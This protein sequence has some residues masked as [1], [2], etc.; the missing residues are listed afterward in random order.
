MFG[1]LLTATML[2]S[3]GPV[4]QAREPTAFFKK[5]CLDCHSA[6]VRKGG[7]DLTALKLD[8]THADNFAKWVKIH[9]RIESGEMPPKKQERPET[10]EKNSTVN[11]LKTALIKTELEQL[12]N[13]P[14]TGLRRLTRTEYENT[15]RDLFDMPGILLRNDLPADGS[16]H[17]FD[18][19]SDALD[20]SH[21]NLAKYIE[22]ADRVLTMA[23]A[24]QPNPP[25]RKTQRVSIAS[26]WSPLGACILEGD[27][28]MLKNKE[29]D[30]HYPPAGK[31]RHIDYG[32][33]LALGMHTDV[34]PGASVGVFRH[35][36]DSFRPSFVEFTTIYPGMYRIK[37]AFWSF[38]WDKGKVLP[39]KR[40]EVARLDVW[41]ITGDGRGTGHPSSLLGYFDAPSIKE[42]TYEFTRWLNTADSF[43]FNFTTS[44]IGHEIRG[45]KDRLAGW[46]GPGLACDGLEVEGPIHDHWPPASH[47]TLFGDLPLVEFKQDKQPGVKPPKHRELTQRYQARNQPD[48][49]P[50]T[51]KLW[52]VKSDRPLVDADRL[53]ASFLPRAFRKPVPAELRRPYLDMVDKRLK[54][55]DCFE[56]AM[57]WAYQAALCSPDFL[58]HFEEVDSQP[59]EKTPAPRV[60]VDDFALAARLSY[61]FWNSMP[62]EKLTALAASHKLRQNTVLDQE[63]ERLLKDP[64][65]QRFREDFLGQWLKLRK[66]AANDPDPKLYAGW[67]VDLQDAMVAE[68]NAYFQELLDKDLGASYLIKS[69]FAMLNERL[70]KQYGIPGVVGSKIRRVALPTGSA[71][72]PFLTQAAILKITANGTTT[73]P[74]PRGAFVMD[75]LLGSPPE[76]PPANV[77]AVEPDVRGATTIRAQLAKHRDNATCAA[78]HAKIDP[79]GFALES[80]DVIGGQRERYQSITST[81]PPVD[82]SGVLPDGRPF[83][84]IHE[85][86]TLV[87]ADST[88]LLKN[89][90]ERF[91]IYSTG[92]GLLF[93]DRDAI[94]AIVTKTQKQG[95]GIRTL[96]HEL[97][98]SD[99]FQTR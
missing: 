92:R 82:P 78:C 54:A 47:R 55:G 62:D 69:D 19:N 97:V 20:I 94:A 30:P 23:I 86:Q 70:A 40:V 16:A 22:A 46:T 61:F 64:K 80:F 99:L 90:A 18:K 11:E 8:L 7:L 41:H 74:V 5:Y 73:S 33:H 26:E 60:A 93:S 89:L 95:G 34:S 15:M 68:T 6:D 87:A 53:L 14:R 88:R 76:P 28:V 35:E 24:T 67:R 59:A 44:H 84:D 58:Y 79:P 83:K 1:R 52:T 51:L 45:S 91:A 9:D 49:P 17:G 42:Q 29:P 21:V 71:R 63:V 72:G 85:F 32:A 4:A 77:A 98:R 43:G 27:G 37:T 39:T 10:K 31:H 96:I 12:K 75:R 65:S 48:P 50:H 2:L 81:K 66:I 36:D 56:S 25:L 3:I 13:E 38:T 57:R